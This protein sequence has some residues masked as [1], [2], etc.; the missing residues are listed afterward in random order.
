[1]A[2]S[3]ENPK[4]S[5]WYRRFV[6]HLDPGEQLGELLF[7]LI[8]V[9]TFTLGAGIE[10]GEREETRELLIAALGCNAAWVIIDAA[11]YLIARL[12]ERGRLHRLVKSIRAARRPIGPSDARLDSRS[13]TS[14]VSSTQRRSA[15]WVF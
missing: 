9:L 8:M 11:L 3:S 1:M 14:L 4:A 2:G 12:S 6:E 5:G 7:G 13:T 15:R 10:L